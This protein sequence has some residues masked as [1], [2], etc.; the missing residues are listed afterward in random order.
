MNRAQETMKQTKMKIMNNT[1]NVSTVIITHSGT[2][3][4]ELKECLE[5][6]REQKI[7]P[8][9]VV[10][11]FEDSTVLPDYDCI[12]PS[13]ISVITVEEHKQHSLSEARQIAANA[14]TKDWLLFIDEDV[15]LEQNCIREL[16]KNFSS[17]VFC[18]GGVL[19][20]FPGEKE[21]VE[22]I[23]W[24]FLW[25]QG[26]HTTGEFTDQMASVFDRNPYGALFV[27]DSD[28][29]EKIDGFNTNLGK[30]AQNNGLLQSEETDLCLR[31]DKRTKKAF[32]LVPSAVGFHHIDSTQTQ[33]KYMIRRAFFQGMSKAIIA[34]NTTQELNS[35]SGVLLYILKYIL[36]F[37]WIKENAP[38]MKLLYSVV[39]TA[40]VG[41]GFI[42]EYYLN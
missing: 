33:P 9:E 22:N 32:K 34:K 37:K 16:E 11:Y 31:G 3:Q 12:L 8:D 42:Y 4:S 1:T 38:F 28:V 2:N 20:A 21:L 24:F 30:D 15:T 27:F 14:A 29:F 41:M 5:S 39:L 26:I 40:S 10:L 25:I 19:K 13:K 23:P 7:L 35:E 18:I 36:Y 17:D 6:I